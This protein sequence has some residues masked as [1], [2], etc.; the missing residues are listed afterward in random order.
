M[1]CRSRLGQ[2]NALFARLS[3]WLRRRCVFVQTDAATGL[4]VWIKEIDRHR[5]A[6]TLCAESQVCMVDT[7]YLCL[8]IGVTTHVITARRTTPSC[9]VC[10]NSCWC[11]WLWIQRDTGRLCWSLHTAR[12]WNRETWF[13]LEARPFRRLES[14]DTHNVDQQHI[15]ESHSDHVIG[16]TS[17]SRDRPYHTLWNTNPS[18]NRKL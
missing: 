18:T 11:G 10:R 15:K 3:N 12:R 5:T 6:A 9:Q 13:V 7:G 2:Y 4:R 16:M 14:L 8:P 1:S 17:L